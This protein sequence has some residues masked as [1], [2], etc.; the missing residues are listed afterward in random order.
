MVCTATPSERHAHPVKTQHLH[1]GPLDSRQTPPRNAQRVQRLNHKQANCRLIG[2]REPLSRKYDLISER[3]NH[4]ATLTSVRKLGRGIYD[5]YDSP[6]EVA[7]L[8]QVRCRGCPYL[9]GLRSASESTSAA[10][11]SE[12]RG[13][14]FPYQSPRD[15]FVVSM[16]QRRLFRSQF[17]ILRAGAPSRAA[18]Y[19]CMNIFSRVSLGAN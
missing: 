10:A 14:L 18:L 5:I 17:T 19:R 3:C 11:A 9:Y 13:S 2:R 12:W 4:S 16:W 7:F 6:A 8:T 1:M 15:R